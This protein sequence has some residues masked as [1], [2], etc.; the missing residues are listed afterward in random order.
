MQYLSIPLFFAEKCLLMKLTRKSQ[1][2]C[3]KRPK[4]TTIDHQ[5]SRT[6][7]QTQ[8]SKNQK[9]FL[10]LF[11]ICLPALSLIGFVFQ[12]KLPKSLDLLSSRTGP[13]RDFGYSYDGIVGI[14]EQFRVHCQGLFDD[15]ESMKEEE[16]DVMTNNNTFKFVKTRTEPSYII[17][18]YPPAKDIWVS[19]SIE[20]RGCWECESLKLVK[21]ALEKYEDSYLLDVGGNIGQFNTFVSLALGKDAYALEPLKKNYDHTCRT[22]MKNDLYKHKLH[23]YDVAFSKARGKVTLHVADKNMGGT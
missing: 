10:Y 21:A 6:K 20:E 3:S 12:M 18:I 13:E 5:I 19:R 1:Q 22:L 16:A 4:R 17:S 11:P 7:K 23:L 2:S 9:Y 14:E 15:T 8:S